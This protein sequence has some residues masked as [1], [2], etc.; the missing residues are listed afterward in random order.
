MVQGGIF[1]AIFLIMERCL[2]WLAEW[3][4][5][6]DGHNAILSQSPTGDT[7]DTI[8]DLIEVISASVALVLF[9]V[10]AVVSI[11]EAIRVAKSE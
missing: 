11:I 8:L 10:H 1:V 9:A 6:G 5:R 4:I 7:L 3:S 2:I